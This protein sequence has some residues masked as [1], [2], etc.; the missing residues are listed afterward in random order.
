MVIGR[1]VGYLLLI[2]AAIV[3]LRDLLAWFDT[4]I[5]VLLSGNQLWFTLSPANY[6]SV[7]DAMRRAMPMLWD[8]LSAVLSAPAVAVSLILGLLLIWVFRRR[9]RRR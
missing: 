4:G 5:L 7:T 2:L 1:F 9:R 6:D 8:P 3:G